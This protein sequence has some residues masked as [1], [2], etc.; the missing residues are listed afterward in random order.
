MAKRALLIANSEYLDEHFAPLP[1]AAADA[2]ALAGVLEDPAIGGFSVDPKINIGQRTTMRLVE[3]FFASAKSDDLLVLHMSLHGWKD[4]RNRLFFVAHDTERAYPGSTAIPAEFVSDHMGQSRCRQIVLLLD[5]CYS[6]AFAANMLRRAGQSDVDIA[7]PFAGAGRVVVTASTALQYAH[8]G[9]VLSSMEKAQPS[10]FTAAVVDGLRSGAA[11]LD[12]DGLISVDELYDY[13]HEQVRLRMQEQTPTMSVDSVQGTIH[14]AHSPRNPDSDLIGEM[15]RAVAAPQSWKRIGA[16]HLLEHLLG[17][18]R[19]PT[20]EVA[21]KA[22]LGLVVDADPQVGGKARALWFARGLGELPRIARTARPSHRTPT[23]GTLA[24][25]IDFGTTN[26]SIGLLEEGEVRLIPNAE[27]AL[28]TPS[29]VA[30]TADGPIVGAAAKRQAVSNPEYTVRSV[31]LRLGTDWSIERGADRY[32]AEQIAA[33]I[34]ARLRAD[35]E[36]YVGRPVEGA[37]LTVPAYFTFVQRHALADAAVIAGINALRIINEPTAA[38]VTYGL[39]RQDDEQNVLMFDLGGGTFDV[40]LLEIGGGVCMVKATAGDNHLGGDDWDQRL[41]DYLVSLARRQHGI[42]VSNDTL[43]LQ[44]FKEAAETAKIDLTSASV[45]ALHLPYLATGAAGPVHLD[46][47]ITRG[48][49]EA[50]TRPVLERCGPSI[51]RV[52][53][54]GSASLSDVDRVILVGGSTRMPAIGRYVRKLTGKE[55]YRGLI[56]EG[57]VTGATL[58]AGILCGEVD[59]MLLLDVTPLSLGIETKNGIFTKMVERNTT[60]P[61]KRSEVFTTRDDQPSMAIHVIEGEGELATDSKTLGIL[62]LAG[63]RAPPGGGAEIEV[64]FDI[65]TNGTLMVSAKELATGSTASLTVDR[66]T[67]EDAVRCLRSPRWP[68]LRE[69]VPVYRP[70]PDPPT[71]DGR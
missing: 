5:C 48:E 21:T 19:E 32:S 9:D 43:V 3:S 18:V 6:G 29:V 66:T 52:M 14:L 65:D 60:L 67:V 39:N 34:L 4:L 54:D 49:F 20:R 36:A 11:D 70:P 69:T 25:G 16:L 55:P 33:L 44:R 56:P 41:V 38:A 37:V 27:G 7:A 42:D 8:E 2:T 13:V 30:L 64:T 61:T 46:V 12:G 53:K 24:I 62:E 26:S 45:T 28:I 57:V 47:T 59:D 1:A 23:R 10:V 31:K 40:S 71:N 68:T 17:S 35:A 58:Q 63:L 50:L 15:R 51:T 22:L